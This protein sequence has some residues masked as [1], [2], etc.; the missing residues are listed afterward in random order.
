MIVL[1]NPMLSRTAINADSCYT[2]IHQFVRRALKVRDD[3][4]FDIVWPT[5]GG[6]WTYYNDGLFY[7][8]RVRRLPM[9]FH[10]AKMK[11]VVS[12]CA[13][14]HGELF[15]YKTPVDVVWNH[16]PEIGDLIKHNV[17]SYNPS[18]KSAVVNCHHY[19]IHD[20]LPYP[21]ELDQ[22]H[23][24]L[25]QLVGSIPV[26]AHV[27]DSDHCKAMLFDN[28]RKYLSDDLVERLEANCV[29]IPHGP[30][31]RDELAPYLGTS[32]A[33][34][35]TFAYNHRLQSYKNY[36]QTFEHFEW[37]AST[38]AKFRVVVF[39]MPDD[40]NNM[41]WVSKYPFVDVFISTTR[42]EYL[43]RL[44]SCHANV[45]NSVHETFGISCVES[46][47]FG[48][49]LIAPNGVTFP[50]ITG[51]HARLFDT[52]VQQREAMREAVHHRD[53]TVQL[54]DDLAHYVWSNFT[55]DRWVADYL[56]LFDRVVEPYD[57]LGCLKNPDGIRRAI[58]K[59]PTWEFE[60]LRRTLY[61]TRFNGKIS[62]SAQ[63]FPA[64]RLKRLMNQL[65]YV[66]RR[67]KDGTLHLVKSNG[68]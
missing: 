2:L 28:A 3:I 14:E 16:V 19:V 52:P 29:S 42:K 43:S 61:A 20:S 67:T 33:D 27:V 51:G 10:P 56:A 35:F 45:T 58:E 64:N 34:V 6:D 53:I 24:M 26:D 25:R 37:L 9:R 62:M 68:S 38:G 23:V 17:A 63:S 48:Q 4:F 57:V 41:S 50:Q 18:G 1:I 22:L 44:A 31:D 32:K 21:V 47:A 49:V 11:Q 15:N 13:F 30:L 12:F 66:D 60:D 54:G 8:P 59:K 40:E 36:K 5:N 39:G 7:L 65:G 46:M 55:V